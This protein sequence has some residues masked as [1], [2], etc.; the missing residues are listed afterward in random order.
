MINADFL[1]YGVHVFILSQIY[2]NENDNLQITLPCDDLE[3]LIHYI[4][5]NRNILKSSRNDNLSLIY[6]PIL[7]IYSNGR[8]FFSDAFEKPKNQKFQ[9]PSI[10]LLHNEFIE[11]LQMYNSS[12]RIDDFIKFLENFKINQLINVQ[13]TTFNYIFDGDLARVIKKI[14]ENFFL[15]RH[16]HPDYFF[17]K[18]KQKF[19]VKHKNLEDDSFFNTYTAFLRDYPKVNDLIENLEPVINEICS[20]AINILDNQIQEYQSTLVQERQNYNNEVSQNNQEIANLNHEINL[21]RN[22]ITRIGREF[23]NRRQEIQ[24]IINQA[25]STNRRHREEIGGSLS[26]AQSVISE[27]RASINDL[28]AR[29]SNEIHSYE[30]DIQRFQNEITQIEDRINKRKKRFQTFEKRM[31]G[32]IKDNQKRIKRINSGNRKL[33][34]KIIHERERLNDHFNSIEEFSLDTNNFSGL[35]D[36]TERYAVGFLPNLIS[37]NVSKKKVTFLNSCINFN[38]KKSDVFT[39]NN[40]FKPLNNYLSKLEKDLNKTEELFSLVIDPSENLVEQYRHKFLSIHS[41]SILSKYETFLELNQPEI[42]K[43]SQKIRKELE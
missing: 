20:N 8:V 38:F 11:K 29:E 40:E 22:E 32:L 25:E 18:C 13:I 34:E 23:S 7:Y 24:N 31:N 37:C 39:S 42:G 4:Y 30:N 5:I 17:R 9:I 28:N 15:L 16:Y 14:S 35:L 6:Y 27:A 2:F 33:F 36:S 10:E 21:R 41:E 19:P 12:E 26:D 3:Y 43:I 1:D